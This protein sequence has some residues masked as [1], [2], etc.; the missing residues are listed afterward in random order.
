MK[1]DLETGLQSMWDWAQRQ[2]NRKRFFWGDQYELTEK[3]YE[4]WK[5]E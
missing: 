1:T 2:P 5:N 4:Y 3:M